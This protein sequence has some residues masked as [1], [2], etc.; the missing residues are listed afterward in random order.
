LKSYASLGFLLQTGPTSNALGQR[1]AK[2]YQGLIGRSRLYQPQFCGG[3]R[4]AGDLTALGPGAPKPVQLFSRGKR[5]A[6]VTRRS[7]GCRILHRFLGNLQHKQ[8][9]RIP[10]HFFDIW[11][12]SGC[13]L[14]D[15]QHT[16][17][18]AQA[19]ATGPDLNQPGQRQHRPCERWPLHARKN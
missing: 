14:P 12:C 19:D 8:P 4:Q 15:V 16:E 11:S 6:I 2:M 3:V 10:A 13:I 5:D 7:T 9:K 18:R 1:S 17:T